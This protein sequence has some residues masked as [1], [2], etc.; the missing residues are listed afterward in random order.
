MRTSQYLCLLTVMVMLAAM[1]PFAAPAKAEGGLSVSAAP[2]T[3]EST[4]RNGMVRVYLSYMGSVSQL[5]LIICGGYTAVGDSTV[6]MV[7]GQTA[8]VTFQASS[9]QI[10]LVYGGKTYAMGRK[11]V[12]R[13]AQTP[14]ESGLR[15]AQSRVAGNLHPGDLYLTA[16]AAGSGYKLYPILHVYLENYLN[17][18]VPYEMGA[19]APLEAL[20][21]QAVAARTYTLSRMESRASALYD[22]TDTTSDQV[23]AGIS[24]ANARCA[25][26]I[27]ETRGIVLKNGGKLTGAYY[28]ASNGG[29]TESAANLWGS[30]GYDYLGV[31]D[32]PFDRMN[33]ASPVRSLT[34][35]ADFGASGQSAA[36]KRLLRNKLQSTLRAEG[37]ADDSAELITIREITPHSPK[38]AEPS[39][40]YTKMDFAVDVL[41]G[42]ELRQMTLTL[43][44]FSEMESALGMSINGSKNELWS[45]EAR[46]GSFLIQARRYGHGIG[47]SQRGAMKMGEMGYTYDQILAFYYEGCQ[48]VQYTFTQVVH[49][50]TG[51]VTTADTPA[52]LPQGAGVAA[53]VQLSDANAR[54]A[55]LNAPSP[56]ADVM[57]GLASG[58]A[59]TVKWADH[60]WA[61]IT[62]GALTGFVPR[63]ALRMQGEVSE[64]GRTESSQVTQWA[65]VTASGT[66]NLRAEPSYQ[67]KVKTTIPEGEVVP[68][69]S[70]EGEWARVQFGAT[71]GYAAVSYLQI[72]DAYPLQTVLG[73]SVEAQI[74]ASG[75]VELLADASDAGTALLDLHAGD[76]VTVLGC[77]GAWRR[78]RYGV[79]EGWVRLDA[80]TET[81]EPDM[82]EIGMDEP[83][84]FMAPES[85]TDTLAVAVITTSSGSLNLRET[86]NAKGRVL[87]SMPRGD[88]LEVL[89]F[90]GT[91]V[92]ARYQ[93]IEGY[94]QARYL[95][96]AQEG[97]LND[98][99][100]SS[101][102]SGE[103]PLP[104]ETWARVTT[105]DGKLNLRASAKKSAKVLARIPQNERI[106]V[107]SLSGEWAKTSYLGQEGF[108]QTRYLTIDT[109][110]PET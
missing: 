94:V 21:A 47:M 34:V 102:E 75:T 93:G 1:C 39:R 91:W 48:Q 100:V 32:D 87:V 56:A 107:Y 38:Y 50:S 12:L 24:S 71:E 61:Q 80:L 26:A 74:Y 65:R 2:M 63:D 90:T 69:Y 98:T 88:R 7:D 89:Q 59:V 67:G 31:K 5:N 72:S 22:V 20:K 4:A 9:G 73:A 28:T 86:P 23:Y 55:V 42:G 46:S 79:M 95:T 14:G 110:E 58:S 62:Q 41:T 106:P 78:V 103:I 53:S 19:S 109:G 8:R 18:V 44:I 16:Q 17:G 11:L 60:T 105:E 36:L 30:K 99:S 76:R 104:A 81:I 97:D 49:A 85:P 51:D 66:L 37:K 10:S 43:N 70:L 35:Y 3:Y 92:R 33:A 108:V 57:M 54:L 25:Q 45:V 40:L 84:D 52:E 13:R 82:P 29:Q 15:I 6:S 96:L 77:A 27:A 83:F 101:D 68:V 64:Q